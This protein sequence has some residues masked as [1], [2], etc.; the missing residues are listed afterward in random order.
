MR[1]AVD[2]TLNILKACKTHGVKRVT[3]TSSIAAIMNIP[4]EDAPD[5]FTE[6]HWTVVTDKTTAYNKG[7]TCAERAAWD[8]VNGMDEENRI[9][10]TTLCPGMMFGPT[11]VAKGFASGTFVESFF[12]G[13]MAGGVSRM[14]LGVADIRDAATAHIRCLERDE[15]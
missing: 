5:I 8:Y 4:V 9:E 10:L 3:M 15:A 7:K 13:S 1:T 6:E 2:G 14:Q 12:N 11:E